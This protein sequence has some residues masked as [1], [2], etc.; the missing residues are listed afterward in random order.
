MVKFKL[1]TDELNSKY[2][3]VVYFCSVRWLSCGNVLNRFKELFGEIATFLKQQK[4]EEDYEQIFLP[5]WQHEMFF[6][7]DIMNHLNELNLKLQGNEFVIH[8]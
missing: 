1:L 8:L 6:L 7:C 4:L 3:D 5:V 2:K